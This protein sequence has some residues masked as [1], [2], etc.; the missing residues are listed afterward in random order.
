[1]YWVTNKDSE[2]ISANQLR[3]RYY[4]LQYRGRPYIRPQYR[5]LFLPDV[6]LIVGLHTWGVFLL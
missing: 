6:D 4:Y 3:Y 5:I 2:Y 1:M